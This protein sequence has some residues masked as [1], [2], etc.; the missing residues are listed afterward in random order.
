MSANTTLINIFTMLVQV[1]LLYAS[2]FSIA[3]NSVPWKTGFCGPFN[4][5]G[6]NW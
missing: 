5:R 1:K 6:S 2:S 4:I 3:D